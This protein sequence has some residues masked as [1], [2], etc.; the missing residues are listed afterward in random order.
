MLKIEEISQIDEYK[1][2]LAKDSTALLYQSL[3]YMSLL[4]T[5]LNARFVV[6]GCWQNNKLIAALPYMYKATEKGTVVNSNPYYGSNGSFVIDPTLDRLIKDQAINM[7]A[8]YVLHK[9]KEMR[10]VSYTY[11]SNPFDQNS[12]YSD[13]FETNLI[14]SRLGQI[15]TLPTY[16][17]FIDEQ[18]FKTYDD[19]RPRNIKKAIKSGVRVTTETSLESL[20]FLFDTHHENIS[21]IGGLAKKASFFYEIQS[22]FN[23]SQYKIWIARYDGK[24][25]AGLLCFYFNKT[26]EYFTPATVSDYRSLQPSALIIHEAMKNASQNKYEYWN[27]GGTWH[28]QGGVYDFKKKWGAQDYP[29]RYYTHV[30]DERVLSLSKEELLSYFYGFYV[31]P[32]FALKGVL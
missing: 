22:V 7:L 32:F 17:D 24:M 1:N 21:A 16:S 6:L 27:W 26:V 14:D 9:C 30:F 12:N 25:I 28:S 10:A 11:I 2:L 31:V 20:N 5:H 18:L 29:Y 19:P 3:E 4:S 8:A 15:T 13:I 23:R